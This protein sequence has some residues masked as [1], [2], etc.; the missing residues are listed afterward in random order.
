[1]LLLQFGVTWT[2][3]ENAI[4]DIVHETLPP[5]A[6]V[7]DSVET[8]TMRRE[9]RL[10]AFQMAAPSHNWAGLWRHPRDNPQ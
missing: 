1:M 3:R 10:N 6:A 5:Q 2:D 7:R 8:M 4:G 9:L